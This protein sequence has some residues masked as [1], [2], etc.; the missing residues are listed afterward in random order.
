M[1][2][3]FSPEDLLSCYRRGVFPM[4]DSRDDPRLFLVDP[5][6][7]GL[8]PLDA[9]HIPKRLTRRIIQDPFRITFDTAFTRVVE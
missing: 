2:T 8:L 7:R 9:F 6:L 1:S 3:R 4:A 5:E